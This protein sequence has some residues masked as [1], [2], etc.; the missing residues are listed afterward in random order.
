MTSW[1]ERVVA[2]AGD[3][4]VAAQEVIAELDDQDG[5]VYGSKDFKLLIREKAREHKVGLRD[6]LARVKEYLE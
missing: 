6:L 4:D 3:L 5:V 2:Y 1:Y